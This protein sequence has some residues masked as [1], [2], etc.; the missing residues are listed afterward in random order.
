MLFH[1]TRVNVIPFT[2]I[3]KLRPSL[4]RFSR[5]W[6]MLNSNTGHLLYRIS[7]KSDNTWTVW[8]EM[9]WRPQVKYCYPCPDL[10]RNSHSPSTFLWKTSVPNFIQDWRKIWRIRT[11]LHLCPY[12]NY[13]YEPKFKKCKC[14]WQFFKALIKNFFKIW[15]TV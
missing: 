5:N 11:E 1:R 3:R 4:G 13:D 8:T 9:F 15:Q 14:V 10:I 12:I 2:S 7:S 6:R